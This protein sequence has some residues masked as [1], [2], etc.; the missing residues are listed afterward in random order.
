MLEA[1]SGAAM[2]WMDCLSWTG[3]FLW[4]AFWDSKTLLLLVLVWVGLFLQK[5]KELG[6]KNAGVV[7][8]LKATNSLLALKWTGIALLVVF[9]FTFMFAAPAMKYKTL[10]EKYAAEQATTTALRSRAN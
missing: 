2:Y 6:W 1:V 7:V 9:I 5:W 8:I 10:D 3:H 4:E